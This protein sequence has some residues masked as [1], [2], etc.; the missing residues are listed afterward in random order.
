VINKSL[1]QTRDGLQVKLPKDDEART[2]PL[3]QD[4]IAALRFQREAQDQHRRMFGADY[5]DRG[6]VFCQ[7]NG[8]YLDPALATFRLKIPHVCFLFS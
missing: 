1:E 8:D 5:I 3:P 6:L 4:A 2:F 7:P